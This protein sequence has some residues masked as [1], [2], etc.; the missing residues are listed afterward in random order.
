M[1][2][3]AIILLLGTA[4]ALIAG[5]A[6][7]GPNPGNAAA[8]VRKSGTASAAT[9]VAIGPA[10]SGGPSAAT[11]GTV[12]SAT[13]RPHG[14]R[15]CRTLGWGTGPRSGSMAMSQAPLYLVRVGQHPCYDRVVLDVNGPE[16]V[17]YAVRYVP[18]VEADGSGEPVPVAG[19]ATLEV[20]VRAPIL[21]ADSQ[22]HQ[23]GTRMPRIGED[24]VAP[25]RLA[26]WNSLR[27]VAFAGSFEGQTTVTVGVRTQ[28]PVRVF[29]TGDRGYRH[30]VVDIA[31]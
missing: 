27:H 19:A 28:L 21:G 18:V 4:A 10:N 9:A 13:G 14:D 29:V 5:C 25:E 22:G 23:P 8:A 15:S 16:T 6:G 24:L 31:H 26:A 20:I 7:S 12:T 2:P 3:P 1:R 30:I 17:G 11:T